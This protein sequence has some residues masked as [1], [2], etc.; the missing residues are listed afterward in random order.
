MKKKIIV[1]NDLHIVGT[2][3]TDF[4]QWEK[5]FKKLMKLAK[6]GKIEVRYI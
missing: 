2:D 5:R 6:K 3:K 1:M 4:V